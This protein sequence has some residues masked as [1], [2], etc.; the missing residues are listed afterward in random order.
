MYVNMEKC[1]PEKPLSNWPT[2]LLSAIVINGDPVVPNVLQLRANPP[3]LSKAPSSP[4]V[5]K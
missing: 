2:Y 4:C 3:C 1:E 5:N